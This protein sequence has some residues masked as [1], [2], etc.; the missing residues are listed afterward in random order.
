MPG[1]PACC[2]PM[3]PWR[4]IG[5]L[6]G[7]CVPRQECGRATRQ[8]TSDYPVWQTPGRCHF[9]INS[10][11]L[12]VLDGT[13]HLSVTQE[14]GPLAASGMLVVIALNMAGAALGHT[15]QHH[16]SSAA[17]TRPYRRSCSVIDM[18]LHNFVP[19]MPS[20][21]DAPRPPMGNGPR[22]R[23][24]CRTGQYH[25]YNTAASQFRPVSGRTRYPTTRTQRHHRPRVWAV[26]NRPRSGAMDPRPGA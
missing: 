26:C 6:A 7:R 15:P 10:R 12:P 16:Q 14:D 21:F 1:S 19:R 3:P 18:V 22:P 20:H 24:L 8:A 17:T 25:P 13:L 2:A 23:M 4:K 11:L 9:Q 5:D